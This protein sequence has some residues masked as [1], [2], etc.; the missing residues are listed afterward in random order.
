MG[1][2]LISPVVSFRERPIG[3]LGE[4]EKILHYRPFVRKIG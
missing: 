4:I 2:P 3:R 1:V